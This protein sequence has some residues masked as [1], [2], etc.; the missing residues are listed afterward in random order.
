MAQLLCRGQT[1][2]VACLCGLT[3]EQLERECLTAFEQCKTPGCGHTVGLHPHAP[4]AGGPP[5]PG[6]CGMSLSTILY[7]FCLP[8]CISLC[9]R[10]CESYC[11]GPAIFRMVWVMITLLWSSHICILP[12]SHSTDVIFSGGCG[13]GRTPPGGTSARNNAAYASPSDEARSSG[14]DVVRKHN[15]QSADNLAHSHVVCTLRRRVC[16]VD[17]TSVM[18]SE[19]GMKNE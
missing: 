7:V 14:Q 2:N 9:R 19:G 5:L 10:Y 13:R 6:C 15:V 16:A 4:P 18:P 1:G 12:F 17:F 3:Q 11:L 8:S